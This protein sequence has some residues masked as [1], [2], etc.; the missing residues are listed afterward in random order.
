MSFGNPKRSVPKPEL[1]GPHTSSNPLFAAERSADWSHF[2]RRVIWTTVGAL[3]CGA[4]GYAAYGPTFAITTV[5]VRGTQVIDPASIRSVTEQYLRGYDAWFIPRRTLWTLNGQG[6]VTTLTK[7][8]QARISIERVTVSKRA[9]HT[10]DIA[11]TERVPVATWSD[12]T[13][14]GTLD[15]QGVI[16][17]LRT[18][19]RPG[20][21][22][23]EDENKLTFGVDT[24]VVKRE[25]V[26]FV[27]ALQGSLTTAHIDVD[28]FI[29]P[30]P[31]CP[32]TVPATNVNTGQPATNA[33]T[34]VAA[35][36]TNSTNTDLVN[37]PSTIQTP[38][39]SSCDLR[40]LKYSSQ[41]I[42]VQL[43][44]GPRILFDRQNNM[45]QAVDALQRV[46]A[47]PNS[48]AYTSIDVRFGDRVYVK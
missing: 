26:A 38:P 33:N 31:T 7:A 21:P 39:E 12:G 4:I 3:M 35:P 5:N 8:I 32:V 28:R 27:Q 2:R 24:S 48:G 23:I 19:R 16:I 29:I 22:L 47:Q 18:D 46:L 10:I 17:D 44:K 43:T 13:N 20:L 41:E 6:L 15:R 11:V 25:V 40:S 42:H 36:T 30:V 45:Q 37:R 14:Y 1:V 34:S 9:P